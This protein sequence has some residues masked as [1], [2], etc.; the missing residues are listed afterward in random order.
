MEEERAY[1]KRNNR[2]KHD[3]YCATLAFVGHLS[4]CDCLVTRS[5]KWAHGDWRLENG[6]WGMGNTE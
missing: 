3:H 6:E 4:G 5:W 1:F 2:L